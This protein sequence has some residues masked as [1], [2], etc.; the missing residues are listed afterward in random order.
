M[1]LTTIYPKFSLKEMKIKN[2]VL[3]YI[4]AINILRA[5]S[6]HLVKNSEIPTYLHYIN[7]D[8]YHALSYMKRLVNKKLNIIEIEYNLIVLRIFSEYFMPSENNRAIVETLRLHK[9]SSYKAILH[10]LEL[11]NKSRTV[12]YD[13]CF[14]TTHHFLSALVINRMFIDLFKD[15]NL[16]IYALDS[17][18]PTNRIDLDLFYRLECI[19]KENDSLIPPTIL[20]ALIYQYHNI[21][22]KVFQKRFE[23][24]IKIFI[25][26]D[27]PIYI[28]NSLVNKIHTLLS[29]NH[30]IKI[31]TNLTEDP[32]DLIIATGVI[33]CI[34]ANIRTVYVGSNLTPLDSK[35]LLE[36]VITI[37]NYK[38][39]RNTE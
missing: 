5:T 1:I 12:P 4:L 20:R 33:G 32:P 26:T 8:N 39:R 7:H 21:C 14:D 25:A 34:F 17:T 18:Y 13:S 3:L 16:D 22:I 36:E 6:K 2:E 31:C 37:S 35:V 30:N 19:L 11:V 27:L 23:P 38:K 9:A 28:E 15:V 24:E 29:Q 10:I